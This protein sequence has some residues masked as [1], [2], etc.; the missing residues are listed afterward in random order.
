M[1]HINKP[2]CSQN[3]FGNHC[4]LRVLIIPRQTASYKHP[5]QAVVVQLPDASQNTT[6]ISRGQAKLSKV[7]SNFPKSGDTIKELDF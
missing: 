1:L 6:P 7:R 4:F 3:P 2:I 5:N